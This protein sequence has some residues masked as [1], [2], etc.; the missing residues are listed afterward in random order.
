MVYSLWSNTIPYYDE[1]LGQIPKL[2]P[3]PKE[4]SKACV[5]VCPGGG[6]S[7]LCND[8]EGE[9]IAQIYNKH[10][11]SAFVLEYRIYPYQYP[12]QLEDVLR[13]I[14]V[15]R[16]L[17][18]VYGYDEDKIAILGFSAGGH[19]AS[20][21]VTH[22]DEGKENGDE[23]DKISSRP[24]LGILCYPVITMGEYTDRSTRNNLLGNMQD[25][26]EMRAFLSSELN[27]KDNSPPCFIAHTVNDKTVPV[28]NS[29]ML[30]SA[31]IEKN[32]PVE[33]HIFPYG[34]HG[35][36]YGVYEGTQHAAQWI[37]L[38]VHYIQ[39]YLL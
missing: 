35:F 19:L 7:K 31:L 37:D 24:N 30:A 28:Q 38:S 11:I 29:M 32:I 13:A 21:A 25:D 1:N 26:L 12:T 18:S 33:L 39:D 3:F 17:A 8:R 27:V 9:I 10:G 22:F 4:N 6:Y 5:I 2:I 36:S 20:M 16:S 14:R 34:R 23:I 15:V